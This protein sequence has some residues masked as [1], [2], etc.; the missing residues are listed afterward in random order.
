M[1]G[2]NPAFDPALLSHIEDAG[3]N[4]SAPPQQR[5][6]DGWLL[7]LSPGKAKRARCVNAVALGRLPLEQKLAACERAY[8]AAELPM[9]VR[10]T[11][12]S[13]P[14][15][16]DAALVH[17]GGRSVGRMAA[18]RRHPVAQS[19]MPHKQNSAGRHH[20]PK[21]RRCVTNWAEYEAGLRRRGSLTMWVTDEAIAAW[22]AAPRATP[23]GQAAYSDSAIQTCLMLRAAFKLP[24][25]QAEGL[26]QS[27]VE[28]LGGALAVPDHSTVSRRAAKLTWIARDALPSGPLHV[29]IDSTRLKVF[30]AGEWLVEKHGR[31][32]RRGWRKLHLAVDAR[33]GQIVAAA[34]TDQDVD[35]ASQVGLLL[36]QIEPPLEQITADGAYDG[37]PTYQTI[38]AH[39]DAV[40]VVIPPRD[41]AVPS[42]GFE[43]DPSVRDTHLLT[44]ASL[45]RMGWQEVTDY[46]RRALVETAMGRYKGIIGAALRAR[47]EAAQR[48]E[49]IVGVAVLNRMLDAGRPNSVRRQASPE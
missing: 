1:N 33:N 40:A 15:G 11:P 23:G 45:G 43:A 14:V 2:L 27:V 7:R 10:I 44:I 35:D 28:L 22:A 5:W 21:M 38:A 37:E 26:M 19:P 6:L 12:F 17:G 39:D 31:R 4:A 49:A 36:E 16:L 30:G 25:R 34:L 41:T 29:L 9:I 24:L 48:S 46:G 47:G 8:A 20:I 18:R 3:L 42:A 32:S 13:L